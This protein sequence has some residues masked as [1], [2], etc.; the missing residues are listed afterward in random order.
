MVYAVEGMIV[1]HPTISST[2]WRVARSRSS[3]GVIHTPPSTHSHPSFTHSQTTIHSSVPLILTSTLSTSS[4]TLLT[5]RC[6]PEREPDSLG[7]VQVATG[8]GCRGHQWLVNAL[9]VESV[10][11]ERISRGGGRFLVGIG[12]FRLW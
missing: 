12:D 10:V 4:L 3:Q 8:T 5:P 2:N 6:W 1:V 11:E 9:N 7:Q